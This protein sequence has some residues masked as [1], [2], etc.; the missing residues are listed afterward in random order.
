MVDKKRTSARV[1]SAA[2]KRMEETGESYTSSLAGVT[3]DD[4]PYGAAVYMD[5]DER[6]EDEDDRTLN[7]LH[8]SKALS[9]R[10]DVNPIYTEL[11]G[12]GIDGSDRVDTGAWFELTPVILCTIDA[13]S[14]WKIQLLRSAKQTP[15]T[16]VLTTLK[17]WWGPIDDAYGPAQVALHRCYE[18]LVAVQRGEH[19]LWKTPEAGARA[20]FPPPPV[21]GDYWIMSNNDPGNLTPLELVART[22]SWVV[23][24][25][26]ANASRW[27][28]WIE[29]WP[30]ADQFQD[31]AP[32]FEEHRSHP[33]RKEFF[34]LRKI[35]AKARGLTL[36]MERKS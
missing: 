4:S 1:R 36:D 8:I 32:Y 9:L 23:E 14:E 34:R 15:K 31:I 29:N 13:Q 6:Y 30:M 35:Y 24:T 2:R 28:H 16:A 7:G 3:N 19:R 33:S 21:V 22:I 5:D 17:Y 25:W 20:I 10:F 18:F 12:A 11:P 27:E 26:V